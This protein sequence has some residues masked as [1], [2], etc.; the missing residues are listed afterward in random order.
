MLVDMTTSSP[1]L[2][3]HIAEEVIFFLNHIMILIYFDMN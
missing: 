3:E 2:A 1:E